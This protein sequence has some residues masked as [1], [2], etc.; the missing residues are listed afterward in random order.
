M[1]YPFYVDPA[2]RLVTLSAESEDAVIALPVLSDGS[3]GRWRW[4]RSTAEVR[5]DE[6][7]ARQV[8][9]ERRWD[10]FQIDWLD[11]DGVQRRVVPKTV[12]E[13]SEFA[14]EAGTLQIKN[15]LGDRVF[16]NPKPTG[17]MQRILEYSA[18]KDDLI[19]DFFAGS[20]TMAH[21]V[22]EA[23]AK[24]GGHRRYIC[25]NLPEPTPADS[26]ARSSGYETV[27]DITWA[28]IRAAM[29]TV[30][31]ANRQGLRTF[32]LGESHFVSPEDQSD[33]DLFLT[34]LTIKDGDV[35]MHSIAAEVL[36]REGV[37]LDVPWNVAAAGDAQVVVADGVAVVLT[38]NNEVEIVRE[39]IDLNP[40]V[41]V[42]LEDGFEG[43]DSVKANAFFACR[44]AGITMKTI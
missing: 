16:D 19:L 31:G 9:S 29:E 15:L 12:W 7:V 33:G 17:L 41:L 13:G 36:L 4:G 40:R 1:H 21:A 20:G 6:L 30:N 23:N 32:A 14:N 3:D 2:T 38:R 27:S 37:R 5:L 28:R 18:R 22:L 39:A 24:D 35:E 25:V 42:F 43:N 26:V 11:R 44:Q 8:G 10:V 34:S